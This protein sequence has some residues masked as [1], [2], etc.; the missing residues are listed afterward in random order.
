MYLITFPKIDDPT[1]V[2]GFDIFAI[3][4]QFQTCRLPNSTQSVSNF[5]PIDFL[6]LP[7]SHPFPIPIFFGH[8]FPPLSLFLISKMSASFLCRSTQFSY[9]SFP[10]PIFH[11]TTI[12]L[13]VVVVTIMIWWIVLGEMAGRI[14]IISSV[15]YLNLIYLE[16]KNI[17]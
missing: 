16:F 10:L 2:D 1:E 6:T 12:I 7:N 13:I 9:A 3:S 17:D 4:F 15:F 14:I 5:K 8:H 11:I